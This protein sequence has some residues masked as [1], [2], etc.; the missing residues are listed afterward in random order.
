MDVDFAFICD[1]ADVTNKINALG[2]GFDTIVAPKVPATHPLLFIVLQLKTSLAEIGEKKMEAHLVD[3]DGKEIIPP[4]SGKF[5]VP[6]PSSGLE[7]IG[8]IAV[9]LQNIVFPL[10]GSYSFLIS[11]D[12]HE[13]K[14]IP[15]R[16]IP[17]PSKP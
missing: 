14:R 16:V 13:I 8:R 15:L 5:N 6:R 4:L 2:I 9:A 1:Y 12:G 7:S 3:Q 11:I 17:Q 10:Y